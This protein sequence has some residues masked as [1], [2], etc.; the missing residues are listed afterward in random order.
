MPPFCRRPPP[1]HN[2]SFL[3]QVHRPSRFETYRGGRSGGATELTAVQRRHIDRLTQRYNA[4]TAG[5]K[6]LAE[7]YR[8]VLA[9]PRA[10]A[11]FRTEWKELVYPI[12][13]ARS[14]GARI[15][16]VDGN[17]YV[18][19]V[20]GYGQTAFGHAPDF[21]VKA[22]TAQVAKGFAIGP[23]AELAGEVARLFTELTGNERVTFCNTGSE[24]VMA[25]LRVARA[26]STRCS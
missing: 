25:A 6:R 14:K 17:E 26:S 2:R 11:G 13:C 20:N 21:V 23:Q 5:S 1:R 12:V 7:T 8:P 4:R 22:V 18:D 16:D 24:S 9:D 15:W 19:L 10:V 3:L